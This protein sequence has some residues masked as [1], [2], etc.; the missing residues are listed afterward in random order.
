LQLRY[1]Q[2]LG[3]IGI[4]QL[5]RRLSAAPRPDQADARGPRGRGHRFR[6]SGLARPDDLAGGRQ[7]RHGPRRR[8]ALD[9]P[10]AERPR[11]RTSQL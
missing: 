10:F 9:Q 1:L 4:N 2:T 8:L 11:S 3:D 7:G 5:H 6:T